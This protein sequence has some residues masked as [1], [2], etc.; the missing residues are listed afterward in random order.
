MAID[1]TLLNNL[2][3]NLKVTIRKI[4]RMDVVLEDILED[5]D[6]QDLINRRM[7]I[8][9][10]N[11][12]DI[13]THLA[14]GLDLPRK[15]RASDVFLLLGKNEIISKEIARQLAGAVGFRNILVHEYTKI[16]YRL[17]Y[18]S[19][20]DKLSDLNQF[21]KEVLEFLDRCINSRI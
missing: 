5:E 10:E 11:C 14:A 7:Q 20:A 8:A 12:I 2:L 6:I 19:L 4:E 3:D 15:E 13:A 18:S 21:A 9:V 17:A 16:D 1:K